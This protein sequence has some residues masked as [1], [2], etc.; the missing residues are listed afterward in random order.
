M[1][2]RAIT[3]R[4]LR[5]LRAALVEGARSSFPAFL[6]LALFASGVGACSD[7]ESGGGGGEATSP[8]SSASASGTPTS[9]S[10]AGAGAGGTGSSSGGGD[11]STGGGSVGGGGS[12][13]DGGAGGS[14]SGGA[15]NACGAEES[16]LI[17]LIDQSRACEVDE[18]CQ[19]IVIDC[20]FEG[21]TPGDCSGTFW[22]NRDVDEGALEELVRAHGECFDDNGG[23][24]GSCPTDFFEPGCVEGTCDA[25]DPIGK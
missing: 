19:G 3:R 22:L 5:G 8:D 1:M 15:G 10:S 12:M 16:A 20:L 14:G 6:G 18:D 2:S 9:S 17:E 23:T 21:R 7:D 13:G 11:G 4:K 25:G 24:C